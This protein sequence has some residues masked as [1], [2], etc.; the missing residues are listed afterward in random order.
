MRWL[1]REWLR[2]LLVSEPRLAAHE[3]SGTAAKVPEDAQRADREPS[4][5]AAATNSDTG[6]LF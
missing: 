1:K 6:Q 2:S 5:F 3:H 4:R